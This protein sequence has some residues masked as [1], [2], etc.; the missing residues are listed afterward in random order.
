MIQGD[1]LNGIS[2]VLK[3]F[4]SEFEMVKGRPGGKCFVMA[5]CLEKGFSKAGFKGRRVDGVL[6]IKSKQGK[7]IIYG[8][9]TMKGRGKLI[10]KYHCWFEL[11]YNGETLIIDPSLKFIK[12]D[13]KKIFHIKPHPELPDFII[14]KSRKNEYYELIEKESLKKWV[15]SFE[16][17][18]FEDGINYFINK[19]NTLSYL[20]PKP[21]STD[22]HHGFCPMLG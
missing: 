17:V 6:I 10:G 14:S 2:I 3:I 5:H 18:L 9:E 20:I 16:G 21:G 8:P 1:V 22:F 4:N 11:D 7:N 13:C 19:V 12:Q 15:D